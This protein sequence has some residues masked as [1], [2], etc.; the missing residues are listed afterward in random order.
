MLYMTLILFLINAMP[1]I[2]HITDVIAWTAVYLFDYKRIQSQL[3][4]PLFY[5][6]NGVVNCATGCLLLKCC[7]DVEFLDFDSDF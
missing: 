5:H 6:I 2:G 4:V 3:A 7:T 1:T